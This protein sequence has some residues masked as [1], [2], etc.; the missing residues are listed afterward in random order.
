MEKFGYYEVVHIPGLW[1]HITRLVQ[2]TLMVDDFGV[3]CYT[4]EDA[5]HLLTAIQ[6]LYPKFSID[7]KGPKY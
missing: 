5:E 3:K 4:K 1:K 2:F 7:L 6:D